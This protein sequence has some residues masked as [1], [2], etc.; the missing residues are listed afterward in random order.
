MIKFFYVL[1]GV[2]FSQISVNITWRGIAASYTQIGMETGSLTCTNDWGIM[3][4]LA[5]KI[6]YQSIYM[7]QPNKATITY[8]FT[9]QICPL[10][11]CV[12]HLSYLGK[13]IVYDH[14]CSAFA[15]KP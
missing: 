1:F 9:D 11:I 6:P 8:D 3:F 5:P 12:M 2:A 10:N 14:V 15:L 7:N 4:G 13:T